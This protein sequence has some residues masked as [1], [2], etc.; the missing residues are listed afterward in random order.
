MR[1]PFPALASSGWLATLGTLALA[2]G[3]GGHVSYPAVGTVDGS[4]D[5]A[6]FRPGQILTY[7]VTMDPADRAYMEAHGVGEEWKPAMVTVAGGKG[8]TVDLGLVD[9]RHKGGV[10]TLDMCWGPP[11]LDEDGDPDVDTHAEMLS[12]PRLDEPFCRKISYKFK[13]NGEVK[14]T[15]FHGLKKLNLHSGSRDQTMLHDMLAYGLYYRAGVDAPR[16]APA[17]LYINGDFMG[18]FIAVEDV[19]DRYAQ[20]HY[21]DAAGGNLYKEAWPDPTVLDR[22]GAADYADYAAGF[23]EEGDDPGD[24]VALTTA[25]KAAVDA[26]SVAPLAGI[27]EVDELL[28]YM[29]VDR[30]IKNWDGVTALYTCPAGPGPGCGPWIHNYYWYHDTAADPRFHLVPWDMDNTFQYWDPYVDP[31]GYGAARPVPNWNVKPASCTTPIAVWEDSHVL[32]SGCDPF[33]H[34]LASTQW[35]R[36][37]QLGRELLRGPIRTSVLQEQARAWSQLIEPVIREDPVIDYATWQSERDVLVND[38][39]VRLPDEFQAHLDR[40]YVEE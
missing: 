18:L 11:T 19:D 7:R 8:G 26:G 15:R 16:T 13:F 34:L 30:A 12:R 5:E 22:M 37:R 39:L 38:I 29:A 17:R 21:P 9:F 33:L 40:G 36:F 14:D 25:M 23:Q 24:F 4:D 1:R 28:R 3:G 6:V 27:V 32:P 35:P 2:C 31:H 10:G 20:F